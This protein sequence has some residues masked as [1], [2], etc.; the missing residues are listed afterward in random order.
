MRR[1]VLVLFLVFMFRSDDV[2][3][4]NY[5]DWIGYPPLFSIRDIV[6]YDGSVFGVT[7]G[8]LFRYRPETQEYDIYYKDRGL[9]NNDVLCV[10]ATSDAVFIGFR[11]DGLWR[12]DPDSGAIEQILFP[13]YH[14][15]TSSRPNGIAV[16][17]IFALSDSILFIGHEDGLDMINLVTE[18]LRTY[19]HLGYLFNENTA[20]TRVNIFDGRIW[21]CTTVGLAVADLDNPNLE[22]P[23]NWKNYTYTAAGKV[24]GITC[25]LPVE[26]PYYGVY[27]GTNRDAL[28][29]YNEEAQAILPSASPRLPVRDMA[30]ANGEYYAASTDG[31]MNKVVNL[32]RLHDVQFTNIT[33][34]APG[35]NGV[36][37]VGTE[38]DGLQCY[39]PEGYIDVPQPTGLM[40]MTFYDIDIAPDGA[41]WCATTYRDSNLRSSFQRLQND[42][43][44]RY[45][46]SVWVSSNYAV[47]TVVDGKGIV[48][49]GT[50]GRGVWVILDDGTPSVAEDT[51]LHVDEE[52]QIFM[53]TIERSFVVCSDLVTDK[54]GNIWAA[55]FQADP[56]EHK[57]EAIPQ[58]GAVVVDGYP[59]TKYQ[60]YSPA[61]D[62]LVSAII[63]TMA[64]DDD[65]WV[66]LGTYNKGV[67][68]IYVGEDPFD[69]TDTQVRQLNFS[70]GLLSLKINAI[71]A[72][73]DGFVW[74]GTQAGLNRIT[75]NG[76]SNLEVDTLNEPLASASTEVTAIEV[77]RFNNKWIATS[78]GLVKINTEN[79][80]EAVYTT[81]NS[82]LF[83]NAILSLR[84][85]DDDDVLWVGTSAGLNR[86]DIFG[87]EGISGE[88]DV[89]VYPNPFE[90]WGFNSRVTFPNLDKNSTVTIYTFNGDAVA[91]VR[92]ES[93]GDGYTA[94]W[95]ARNFDGNYVGSGVYFFT[96][97]N[98]RRQKFQDKMVVIRR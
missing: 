67:T 12:F 46:M 52:R 6:A 31:L 39:T 22:F 96:G 16:N 45:D 24:Y 51:V 26:R 81:E 73:R 66:W 93:S 25:V 60:H 19:S 30:E 64:V 3:A 85:D 8:G 4:D 91:E 7:S 55:N 79:K 71:A 37:W 54:H 14:V 40:N 13:E 32:W 80:A 83:S 1:C 84:Y 17:D 58:S 43:W 65:G 15:R 23:E 27:V 5:P 68:G 72:D 28:L 78:A 76:L 21:A 36:L 63:F 56:P 59:I 70:N 74:V 34:L 82:G 90:V 20:V 44:S 77:D 2:H 89:R 11:E 38:F 47:T 10:D 92:A 53:P 29:L 41:V 33:S 87:R 42:V 62:G 75:K 69:K 50:W 61:E 94:T 35:D 95:D 57:I 97:I 18:E 98:S 88:P 9:V 86:F 49:A 48:W